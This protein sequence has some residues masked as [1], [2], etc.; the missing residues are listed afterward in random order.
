[1]QAVGLFVA[2]VVVLLLLML[3]SPVVETT[4]RVQAGFY[5]ASQRIGSIV[6]DAIFTRQSLRNEHDS[7]QSLVQTLANNEAAVQELSAR[8]TE[9]ESTLSYTQTVSYEAILARILSRS[10]TTQ[11]TLLIDQGEDDG[12]TQGLAAI[13]GDGQ[14][15]GIVSETTAHTAT[16]RLLSDPQSTV[17]SA[18]LGSD[19][20][21]GLIVGE[22]GYLLSMQYI[23]Q[24]QRIDLSDV[25]VTSGLNEK[26][27][28]GIVIG[29]VDELIVDDADAFQ[30][31]RIVQLIN[32]ADI[33][34]VTILRLP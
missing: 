2:I 16:I 8:V 19:K 15:V 20:T 14:L 33:S 7:Y 28:S 34:Y 25:V 9:L 31:A 26:I 23:P 4:Q 17:A 5:D 32:D 21:A 29:V 10:L 27:P 30:E 3:A 11:Q 13:A 1:M 22:G 6:N 24:T 12:V 18:I